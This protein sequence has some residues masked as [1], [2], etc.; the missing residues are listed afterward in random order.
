VL[1]KQDWRGLPAVVYDVMSNIQ[2][3]LKARRGYHHLFPDYGLTPVEGCF[4]EENLLERLLVE[5]P[6][7]L[8]RYEPRFELLATDP[9]SDEE[10]RLLLR[11]TG[12]IRDLPG[13]FSFTFGVVRRKVLSVQFDPPADE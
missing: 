9:E 11:A 10:G 6:L 13:T 3:L 1:P 4:G 8:S 12:T 7:V 5:L 2:L